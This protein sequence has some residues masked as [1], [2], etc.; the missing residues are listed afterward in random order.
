MS[1]SADT[2]SGLGPDIP[3]PRSPKGARGFRRLGLRLADRWL[4]ISAL[5]AA[6]AAVPVL[7][8]LGISL[9]PTLDIWL[10]L[11]STVLPGYTANT[12]ILFVGVGIGTTVIG[13]TTAWLVTMCR[14]PGWRSFE[15]ALLLPLAVPSY[16]LAFVVTDMLEFSGPVQGALRDMFGWQT[17]RDYWFPDIRTIGGAITM[18]SLT[19]YPY[20]Y[21][22]ARSA[23]LQ[24]SVCVLEVSRT[25]GRGG[26]ASFF[27]VA[28]PLARPAI[29]AGV[30]L[31]LMETLND[32]GTVR[33]F[34]VNT[35]T[36]GIFDVWLSY[37]NAGGAA[38]I[39]SVLLGFVVLLIALESISRRQQRFHHT[40]SK[41]RDLPGYRLSGWRKGAAFVACS[42]PILLGFVLPAS[43][44]S[45]YAAE[46]FPE[47]FGDR[48]L[49]DAGS[50][51]VLAAVSA[52]VAVGVG[53]LL[54]YAN[55]IRGGRLLAILTRLSVIGY[56]VPGAV[57]ALGIIIPFG[58]LDNRVDAAMRDLFGISTGL[59]LSGTMVALVFAYV[60]R[61]LAVS[62]GAASSGLAKVTR[63]MDNAA[64]M[65]GRTP[66]GA[67]REVHLP[68]IRA[69]VITAGLLVFVDVMKELPM[70]LILRPF[71]F[72][73]LATRAYDYASDE[74]LWEASLP[75]LSIVLVGILP[76]ILMSRALRDSRPGH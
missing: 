55:R 2:L 11:A 47:T 1:A 62:F 28:L 20:V 9:T 10:H 74:R 45:V 42:L 68:L 54:A 12:L 76:V 23:F 19:L 49:V 71:G 48:F 58:W 69:S 37:N 32:F 17:V 75:A 70:T 30:A 16:I 15:W 33:Y 73:T 65:L 13:V 8:V 25:L 57:L 59:L 36:T 29:V 35:F 18:F 27:Q 6:L 56:A 72:N 63:N 14:F 22:L 24:Q 66:F 5:T 61:F 52:I 4:L 67:L 50:S 34:A 39:A 41:L 31:A 21:L 43:V 53:L 40:S 38:Q 64:R 26:V 46:S 44:L 51:L 3:D 60:T 7:T